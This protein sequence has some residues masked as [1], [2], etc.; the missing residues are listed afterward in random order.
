MHPRPDRTSPCFGK[1]LR[2]RLGRCRAGVACALAATVAAAAAADA[3]TVVRIGYASTPRIDQADGKL[4]GN[5][6]FAHIAEEGWLQEQLAQRHIDLQWVP[7]SGELGPVTNEDFAAHR[8]D[9]AQIGDLPSIILNSRGFA[10]RMLVGNGKGSDLYLVVPPD[11][12]ARSIR[13][14]KGKRISVQ[15]ARPWELGFR[16]LAQANGLQWSD[17]KTFNLDPHVSVSA[18]ASGKID[19]YFGIS[20]PAFEYN[21]TGRIIWSTKGTLAGKVRSGELWGTRDFIQNRPDITQLVVTA[22]V[23]ALQ[24]ESQESSRAVVIHEAEVDGTPEQVVLARLDDKTVSWHDHASPLIDDLMIGHYREAARFAFE[25][26]VISHPVDAEAL[27][28]TR[29]LRQALAD[30]HLQTAWTPSPAQGN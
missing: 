16:K 11:S 3:P 1:R 26:G 14:L 6:A 4:R 22:Y 20:G 7:I 18:L 23:R 29:F 30:L 21:H 17:F 5:V 13:D 19:A 27:F 28:D 12:T 15:S 25:T 10:T 8:I 9:F 24:W 2:A